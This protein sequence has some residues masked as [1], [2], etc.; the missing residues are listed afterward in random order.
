MNDWSKYEPPAPSGTCRGSKR[1]KLSKLTN[2][3]RSLKADVSKLDT[4]LAAVLREIKGA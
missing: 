2:P 3:I 1:S 4:K